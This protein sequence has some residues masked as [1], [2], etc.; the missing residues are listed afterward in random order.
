MLIFN[1]IMKN[2]LILNAK[3]LDLRLRSLK[4]LLAIIK[5]CNPWIQTTRQALGMST[6]ALAQRLD[7]TPSRVSFLEKKEK[8][9]AV[10][11]ETMRKTA[12]AL[13]C[14]FIYAMV[15]KSSFEQLII[16]QAKK[17]AEKDL[18]MTNH[19]MA[20]EDQAVAEKYRHILLEQHINSLILDPT[21]F[22]GSM[23][24]LSLIMQLFSHM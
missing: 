17:V 9:G 7:V 12:E 19:T 18:N 1:E 22:L 16:E 20:L 5:N 4:D 15:P 14:E 3:L 11:L 24:S 23:T 13:G 6:T 21:V 10:T 8:E 2:K